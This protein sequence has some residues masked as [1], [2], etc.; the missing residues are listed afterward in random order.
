VNRA[1]AAAELELVAEEVR[2]HLP[3]GFEPCETCTNFVP[4]EG[5]PDAR[6]VVVGEAPGRSED[7]A[8]RPFVG[9]AGQLL[10]RL[11]AE[12][13]LER[14]AVFVTNVVKARPPGN[15]DPRAAEI[16]HMLPWL[17]RQLTAIEPAVVVALGRHAL[18][19]LAPG[20]KVTVDHGRPVEAAGRM[21][22]PSYHPAAALR[23]RGLL[24]LVE[25][26]FRR[27]GELLRPSRAG[28]GPAPTAR[29]DGPARAAP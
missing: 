12:A 24:Q 3:C 18:Q 4:G 17:E 15:R 13:G 16:S 2:A 26:D 8:G 10:D 25:D 9:S 19:V 21:V 1:A 7:L 23:G 6:V 5:P 28:R 29:S 22:F 11:L 14:D 27:L 20:A